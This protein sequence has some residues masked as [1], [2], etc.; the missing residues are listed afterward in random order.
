VIEKSGND[1]DALPSETV[2]S[3]LLY[4]PSSPSSACPDNRPVLASNV[5]QLGRL[6]IENVNVSPSVS[7]AEG[8]KEYM[9]P[10]TMAGLGD[11]KI[12]G[13]LL[14]TS[15]PPMPES[16]AKSEPPCGVSERQPLTTDIVSSNAR[17]WMCVV[18]PVHILLCPLYWGARN[19]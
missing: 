4:T 10:I 12:V 19:V 7:L 16:D 1:A 14:S 13:A 17:I 11:P 18:L 9:V 6:R 3:I 2:I 5:A 8:V 15:P